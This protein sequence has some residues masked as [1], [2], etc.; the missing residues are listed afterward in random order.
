[1]GGYIEVYVSTSLEICEERDAKGLYKKARK[2]IIGKFTGV[3]DPYE[4]PDSPEIVIDSSDTSPDELVNELYLKIC[5]KG[6]IKKK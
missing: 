5:D 2:G 6:Y 4:V 1:M 3:S